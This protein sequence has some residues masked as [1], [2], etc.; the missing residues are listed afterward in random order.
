M[1]E[2]LSIAREI[3]ILNYPAVQ[4]NILL[5]DFNVIEDIEL[6]YAVKFDL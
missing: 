5:M 1:G 4:I 2:E 6:K 3:Q